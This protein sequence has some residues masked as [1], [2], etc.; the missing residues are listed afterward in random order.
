MKSEILTYVALA[1]SVIG[2]VLSILTL[3]RKRKAEQNLE[4]L[5]KK[6]QEKLNVIS[7]IGKIRNEMTHSD[8]I[9]SFDEFLIV[10]ETLKKLIAQLD[11][12]QREEILESLEQ[13]S[14]KGQLDYLNKIIHLSGSTENI[15]IK[16]NK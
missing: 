14:I 12:K 8:R 9:L 13:K 16:Q 11:E 3:K 4:I 15:I 2:V 1:T 6:N 5:L 10:Q 7:S